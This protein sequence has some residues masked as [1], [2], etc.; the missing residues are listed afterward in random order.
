MNN[1][2]YS[3]LGVTSAAS[4]GEIKK[5]YRELARKY[6]PDANPDDAEAE[7]KFKEIAM[8][9]EILSDE[10]RRKQYDQF[11]VTSGQGNAGFPGN[12]GLSDIFEAFFG[13]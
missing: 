10:N 7:R 6:H 8:A 11:G 9:Y 12:G 4:A 5:A 1:D 2:L 3:L 13:P